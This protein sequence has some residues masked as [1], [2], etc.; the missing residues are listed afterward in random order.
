[1]ARLAVIDS[2]VGLIDLRVNMPVD[3]NQVEPAVVVNIV[4]GI[5]PT[6]DV[7]GRT[8]DA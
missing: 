4:K 3:R 5:S 7:S 6:H 1:M 8:R 2:D